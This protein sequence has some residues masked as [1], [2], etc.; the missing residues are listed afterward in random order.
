MPPL[1]E[2][3]VWLLFAARA[4]IACF[5]LGGELDKLG[6]LQARADTR[7]ESGRLFEFMRALAVAH[8]SGIEDAVPPELDE[9]A[10]EEMM[11]L[12]DARIE[13]FA[14]LQRAF[15]DEKRA[16]FNEALREQN[17]LAV[18]ADQIA[19]QVG[20]QECANFIG[21]GGT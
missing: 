4:N 20:L 12:Y 11:R 5:N 9:P 18:Q 13:A 21:V 3:R 16:A 14:R 15:L 2:G 7:E 17:E 8:L 19:V 6:R 10:V 1:G